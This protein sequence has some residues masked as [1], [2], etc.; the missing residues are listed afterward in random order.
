MHNQFVHEYKEWDDRIEVQYFSKQGLR[1]FKVKS[2]KMA[3]ISPGEPL[4]FVSAGDEWLLNWYFVQDYGIT[5][6]GPK[7]STFIETISKEEFIEAVKKHALEWEEYVINT[8]SSRPYQ[9]YAILT[10]C[11]ALYTLTFFE[12]TSKIKAANWA[13]NKLP[14]Y[15]YL[16]EKAIEWRIDCRN[17]NINHEETYPKTVEFVNYAI[18]LIRKNT[19]CK[20]I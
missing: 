17:K 7:P 1:D 6:Y 18:E 14:E 20:K 11:R 15:A 16:I 5:L 3:V 13:K 8:K 4:H 2:S 9:A 12:Q 19:D 10:M